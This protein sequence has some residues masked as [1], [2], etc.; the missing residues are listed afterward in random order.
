DLLPF[1]PRPTYDAAVESAFGRRTDDFPTSR[2]HWSPRF[3]FNWEMDGQAETR[4][5]GGA[6]IFVGRPPLAWISAS[7]RFD[8]IGTR[9]LN[10]AGTGI[11]PRFVP[12][13][14]TLPETC[15]NGNGVA[16][17][18]VNLIDPRLTMADMFRAS[19][20]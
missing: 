18:P 14:R 1:N 6:G 19:L 13:P 17:G 10:C 3:G 5:R 11:A 12:D 15:A 16:N 9:T 4:L 20:A 8:G 2:L 7:E